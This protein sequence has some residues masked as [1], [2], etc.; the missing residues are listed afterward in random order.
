MPQ[1]VDPLALA[2][3]H[4]VPGREPRDPQALQ[5]DLAWALHQPC[6]LLRLRCDRRHDAARRHTLRTMGAAFPQRP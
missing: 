6:A 3:A 4:G 5:E 2:A 1:A